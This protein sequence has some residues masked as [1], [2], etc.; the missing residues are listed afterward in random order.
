MLDI[1]GFLL[2]LGATA[3]V[4]RFFNS[5]VLAAPIRA[6]ILRR[7]GP[8]SKWTYLAQCPWC[9]S[10]WVAPI[11]VTAAWL[12]AGAWWFTIPAAALSASYVY[13]LI[14]QHLDP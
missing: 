5:D 11:A 7:H 9:L 3:R 4:T 14:A 2:A 10:I 8:A 12:S 1:G 13:G 6:W